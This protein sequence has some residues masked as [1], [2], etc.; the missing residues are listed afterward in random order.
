MSQ[1]PSAAASAARSGS[2]KENE[3]REGEWG[4][5]HNLE[6]RENQF[7]HRSMKKCDGDRDG[8]KVK[9]L[10]SERFL[11]KYANKRAPFGFNGLGEVVFRRT[12]SRVLEDGSNE[13][14]WQTVQRVVEGTFNMQRQWCDERRLGFSR[15]VAV[16]RAEDMYERIFDMKFLPPGR[17]LWAMGS[18][19]T[20]QKGVYAALNNCA[21]VST[22]C[23]H[24]RNVPCSKPFSFLMDAAMLGVG[25]GF[26]T[27]GALPNDA[28]GTKTGALVKGANSKKVEKYVI[29]DT[30]EGWVDSVAMVIDSYFEGGASCE[31]DYS[32]IRP[33]GQPIKGFGGFSSGPEPLK[34]LHNEINEILK[35]HEKKPISVSGIVD[36]MNLI[37]KCVVAGN[38]RQTA[39]IAFGEFDSQEYLDLKD[40]TVNPE[41]QAFGWASNNSVY[42]ELGMDYGPACKRVSK[43]GEPGFA[44]LEN[45]Q[46]FS[47]MNGAQDFKDHKA[48]G[49]N[50]CLE[51]TLESF[52]LCCLVETF[53]HNH[54]DLEDF[55]KTLE[56]AYLYAKTVTLG[57]T[58]WPESN[59][60]ML[61]NRRI[62][63]SMS[64]LAQF[65]TSRGLHSLKN[66]CETGYER[67]QDCDIK[68]SDEF[69]I[70]RSIKTTSIKPSGT[71]SLLA[72]ATP[73]LHYPLSRYFIRRIRM[74]YDSKLLEPLR[75][76]GY[77]IEDDVVSPKTVVVSFPVDTGENIRSSN[78]MSMW[79]QLS[80][81]SF[82]QK[83][84]ADNQVSCTI[85]FNP[86]TEAEHLPYALDYFQ[87]Q[88][89][90]VS[91]L[92]VTEGG[93]Y[94]QMPYETISKDQYESY[95]NRL[96]RLSLRE[97][98]MSDPEPDKFCDSSNCDI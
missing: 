63:C 50:P 85:S 20:E 45:M 6:R 61:R 11:K 91:F 48:A 73:G 52:E 31:F 5:K 21:F 35:K 57:E 59:R 75:K 71:V 56:S 3:L 55:L 77:D 42:C 18:P 34:I 25:V 68:Y 69:A 58:H 9:P 27:K 89:K 40:Y 79:E 33:A 53:P 66:W 70:P 46:A 80:L 97:V 10:L 83:Y 94:A 86:E 92:P 28:F 32:E 16:R 19:L 38:V 74:P 36:I 76:A 14:W 87:Y 88:L 41:R 49:G 64:G 39:E 43:N 44:W 30:R 82:L 47:R 37:G 60:V 12:Y 95:K 29:P 51:Q 7:H 62:G 1:K 65:I 8:K 93:A 96:S 13:E 4:G 81:A 26:D 15:S 78:S 17:G 54:K 84:W 24:D 72:G 22:D 98:K 23:M 67:I 90:G 2:L